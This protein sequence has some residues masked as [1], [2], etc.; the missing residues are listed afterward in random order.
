MQEGKAGVTKVV[1][2]DKKECQKVE[3]VKDNDK[4]EVIKKTAADGAYPD[5]M[6]I[7]TPTNLPL[8]FY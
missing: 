7:S 1:E 3:E 6:V 4:P 5:A 2:V 8:P